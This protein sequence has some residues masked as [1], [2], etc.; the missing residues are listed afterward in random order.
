LWRQRIPHN[1][2]KNFCALIFASSEIIFANDI[3]ARSDHDRTHMTPES[4]RRPAQ[5]AAALGLP[6]FDSLPST[7]G[8]N[9][10]EAFRLSV[11]HALAMLPGLL[12]RGLKSPECSNPE[13]FSLR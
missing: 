10:T 5:D 13:R 2:A 9:N 11:R 7:A 8:L 12:S 6:V 1:F 4:P 3:V